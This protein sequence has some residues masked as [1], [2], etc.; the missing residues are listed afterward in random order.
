MFLDQQP[1]LLGHGTSEKEA[2]KA[3]PSFD[4]FIH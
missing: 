1:N 4:G 2:D 3:E